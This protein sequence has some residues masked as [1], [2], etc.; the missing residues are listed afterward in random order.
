VQNRS[1]DSYEVLGPIGSGGMGEVYRAH[2]TKLKRPTAAMADFD[3]SMSEI[4]CSPLLGCLMINRRRTVCAM[5]LVG[6]LLPARFHGQTSGPYARIAFLRPH[7][8]RSVEFEAGYI[9]HLAWHR[10]A[11]EKWT[12]YGW[13]ITF[14]DRQRWFVYATFGHPAADF[15]NPVDPAEDERDNVVNVAPYVEYTG[16][17]LYEYLP[18][19]SRGSAT[20]QPAARLEL[21]TVDLTPGAAKAFEAALTAQASRLQ[22]DTLWYRMVGGGVAPRYVRLRPRP[23]FSALINGRNEQALP[24]A[25]EHL[26]AKMTVEV[27]TLRPTMSLGVGSP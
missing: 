2:D 7:D 4:A 26:I 8:G 27:L 20:P 14:G 21:A 12:W 25:V 15:D 19:M 6:A 9:R 3:V 23:S 5:I 22:T 1:Y 13:N 16:S 11:G 24:N 10:Q 18:G 17:A